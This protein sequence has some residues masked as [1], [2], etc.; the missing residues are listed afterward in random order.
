MSEQGRKIM[1]KWMLVL[2]N[3]YLKDDPLYK[4]AD[5]VRTMMLAAAFGGGFLGA[6]LGLIIGLVV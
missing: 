2:N 5:D 4:E 3:P 6:V 1:S